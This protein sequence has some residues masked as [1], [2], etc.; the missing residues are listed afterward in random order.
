MDRSKG[1]K[2]AWWWQ[3]GVPIQYKRGVISIKS[4]ICEI[5]N[6]KSTRS[7]YKGVFAVNNGS[8][9]ITKHFKRRHPELHDRYCKLQESQ[10]QSQ[11]KSQPPSRPPSRPQSQSQ[12]QSGGGLRVGDGNTRVVQLQDTFTGAPVVYTEP[13][14]FSFEFEDIENII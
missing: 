1:P 13:G 9:G 5:C 11:P 4:F 14:P 8:S 2:G 12:S 3:F 6:S 7:P 10:P